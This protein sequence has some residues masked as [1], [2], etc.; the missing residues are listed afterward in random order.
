M[1]DLSDP[2]VDDDEFQW[3]GWTPSEFGCVMKEGAELPTSMTQSRDSI[4]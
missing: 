4:L 1:F 2:E 3:K